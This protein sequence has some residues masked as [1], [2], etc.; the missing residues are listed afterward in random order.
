MHIAKNTHCACIISRL[1]SIQDSQ[2]H[3]RLEKLS[4][5]V[6]EKLK[7]NHSSLTPFLLAFSKALCTTKDL[8]NKLKISQ[9]LTEELFL[10]TSELPTN[11]PSHD[12]CISLLTAIMEYFPSHFW[13]LLSHIDPQNVD[14]LIHLLKEK[15]SS[16]R[17]IGI[18][19]GCSGF[20]CQAFFKS[21]LATLIITLVSQMN[22][23]TIS[24][25]EI[26]I[27]E[28]L[29]PFLEVVSL[30]RPI[31]TWIGENLLSFLFRACIVST[32][33]FPSILNILK[34]SISLH[35]ANQNHL[36]SLAIASLS[37]SPL[38][39]QILTSLFE[40]EELIYIC[41]KTN[42]EATSKHSE[43][44][45]DP[46]I[47]DTSIQFNPDFTTAFC[48][49]TTKWAT[50][51]TSPPLTSGVH[52]WEVF[53]EKCTST[54]NMMIGVSEKN[55]PVNMFVGMSPN[56]WAFYGCN[57]YIYHAGVSKSY[58]T[59]L[60]QGDSLIVE[61]DMKLGS[62]SFSKAGSSFGL[63]MF[64]PDGQSN[65]SDH[66][67]SYFPAYNGLEGKTLYP[68]ISLYD[69]GDSVSIVSSTPKDEQQNPLSLYQIDAGC[70]L[71]HYRI[72]P[73]FKFPSQMAL[74]HLVSEFRDYSSLSTIF[75]E[76]RH[77]NSP[78]TDLVFFVI[79]QTSIWMMKYSISQSC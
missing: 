9:E 22:P 53:I 46:A 14:H 69:L 42:I 63:G 29:L 61:L 4:A 25:S 74:S 72:Y 38:T 31:K 56:S 60:R 73:I 2:T 64:L 30:F 37:T 11:S 23:H 50:A 41:F 58:G 49:T 70:H 8:S 71:K 44:N 21:S 47:S 19:V 67:L 6:L 62:I 27:L 77:P 12:A 20:T 68:S 17:T 43:I 78:F 55:H 57:G 45:F 7:T 79:Q 15:Q 32:E 10:K 66:C 76:E 1:S 28:L 13:N 33:L 52:R 36:A 34:A 3:I 18:L 54:C 65:L 51:L 75:F 48:S 40:F 59:R 39:L 24:L 26:E 5:F 35:R 16:F